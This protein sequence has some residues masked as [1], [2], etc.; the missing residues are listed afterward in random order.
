MIQIKVF[1]PD[2]R[3][4]TLFHTGSLILN[5]NPGLGEPKEVIYPS[6]L[7]HSDTCFG[8]ERNLY[9]CVWCH[10]PQEKNLLCH[11]LTDIKEHTCRK[12]AFHREGPVSYLGV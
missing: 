4:K 10:Q 7:I 11:G 1:V 3:E 12:Q 9:I 2:D 5:E 6:L 8:T